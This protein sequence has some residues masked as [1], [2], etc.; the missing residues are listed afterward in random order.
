VLRTQ[1]RKSTILFVVAIGV[2]GWLL[3]L[4]LRDPPHPAPVATSGSATAPEKP[5]PAAQSPRVASSDSP[6]APAPSMSPA[7]PVAVAAAKPLIVVQ[8]EPGTP[9]KQLESLLRPAADQGDARAACRLGIELAPCARLGLAKAVLDSAQ[10]DL[11]RSAGESATRLALEVQQLTRAMVETQTL[12]SDVSQ[13]SIRNAWRYLY[14]AAAAGNVAAMSRFVRDP[15][16]DAGDANASEGSDAYARSAADFLA[17]AIEGGD[18]RALYQ[19]WY[20][21]SSGRSRNMLNIFARDPDKA[22]RYGTVALHLV[23]AQRASRIATSNEAIAKEI[24]PSRVRAALR[25]AERLRASY[26]ATAQPVEWG[27][28]NGE[29]D[30]GDCWK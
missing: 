17:R 24:G 25:E 21:A 12:C 8:P 5:A 10:R 4:L 28:D 30:A 14:N 1:L 20:S 29:T 18:V 13:D 9:L 23:D 15:G 26:F 3:Y 16:F 11:D 19:A 2:A 6:A 22:L 7:S 27:H